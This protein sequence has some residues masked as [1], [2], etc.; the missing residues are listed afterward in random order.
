MHW[1]VPTVWVFGNTNVIWKRSEISKLSA[2]CLR[3][4]NANIPVGIFF[5]QRPNNT[6]IPQLPI[7]LINSL[8][9]LFCV[10]VLELID[11]PRENQWFSSAQQDSSSRITTTQ[12]PVLNYWLTGKTHSLAGT[13]YPQ[14]LNTM[15]H[16][17]NV[18]PA[19]SNIIEKFLSSIDCYWPVRNVIYC[20]D[21]NLLSVEFILILRIWCATLLWHWNPIMLPNKIS[22]FISCR[23]YSLL[24]TMS[25][26]PSH[27]YQQ[28]AYNV[29][30]V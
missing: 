2:S 3:F 27:V 7:F 5:L 14:I 19:E 11:W 13:S 15:I 20:K 10:G 24:V 28:F 21:N 4:K 25:L 17:K 18:F 6:E 16:F 9:V 12:M 26:V 30:N 1:F 8:N 29:R 23:G 22:E